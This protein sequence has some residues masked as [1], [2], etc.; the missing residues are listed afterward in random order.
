MTVEQ[1]LTG[2]PETL[3]I[4]LWAR[5]VE[6]GKAQPIFQDPKAVEMVSRIDYDFKKFEKT[7]MSQ[8]GVAIRSMILDR[9]VGGFVQQNPGAV[10]VN[11]GAGLDTRCERFKD[12]V[13]CWYDLDLPESIELRSRFFEESENYCLLTGSAFDLSWLEQV[14]YKDKP[15]LLIAE[16]LLMYFDEQTVRGLFAGLASKLSEF[17]MLFEALAPIAVGQS[18]HHDTVKKIENAPEFKWGLKESRSLESWDRKIRFL[19]EWNYFDYHKDR[20]KW[21]GVLA[22]LPFL[23]KQFASRIVHL[24]FGR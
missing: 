9:A 21:F 22:R 8:L 20:W 2:V 18:K 5:A 1:K 17:Q 19:E 11:I 4:P 12:K 16:G 6:S 10:V 7:W 14:D 23:R 3:L 15:F 13:F 24:K